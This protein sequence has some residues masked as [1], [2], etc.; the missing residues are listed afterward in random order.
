MPDFQAF[1]NFKISL[2]RH[3]G[4]APP[5]MKQICD[6]FTQNI[7]IYGSSSTDKNLKTLTVTIL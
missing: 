1:E 2:A 4:F 5:S 7:I 6:N 3:S